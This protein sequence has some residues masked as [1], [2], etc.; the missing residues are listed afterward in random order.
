MSTISKPSPT[1]GPK[2]AKI[3]AAPPP[4]NDPA[5]MSVQPHVL[6]GEV[7]EKETDPRPDAPFSST[8]AIDIG[9]VI[10]KALTAAGLMRPSSGAR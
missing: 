6:E 5:G 10:T 9:A 3:V 8:G 4:S 7:L 1:H 2:I